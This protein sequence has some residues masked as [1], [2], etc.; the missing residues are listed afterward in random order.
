MNSTTELTP[1]QEKE[2]RMEDNWLWYLSGV[3]DSVGTFTA[4]IQKDE[5]RSL[6]FRFTP[7][8]EI[9]RPTDAE[10]VF[11]LLD[12]FC[13]ENQ[14]Q[15][16]ISKTTSASHRKV[17]IERPE[18]IERFLSLLMGGFIQQNDTAEMVV[19]DLIPAVKEFDGESKEEFIEL[20]EIRDSIRE[21]TAGTK[22]SKYDADYFR[23]LWEDELE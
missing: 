10:A 13:E 21:K 14:I 19:D 5:R 22:S 23:D 2:N 8:V 16:Y 1:R 12:E 20:M 11:G 9:S 4:R 7:V 15:Y 17:T 3:V 6:G 18:H